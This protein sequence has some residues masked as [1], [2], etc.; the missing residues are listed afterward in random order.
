MNLYSH[1]SQILIWEGL[2]IN[3]KKT[4]LLHLMF[5]NMK[6]DKDLMT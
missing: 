3:K 2:K 4:F 5:W 6:E 1:R